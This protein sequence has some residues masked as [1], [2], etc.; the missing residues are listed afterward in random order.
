MMIIL[1]L[2]EVFKFNVLY[3]YLLRLTLMLLGLDQQ[4]GRDPASFRV[5][6]G[7]EKDLPRKICPARP[8]QQ[9]PLS[10]DLDDDPL[11]YS[12]EE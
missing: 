8:V 5:T 12:E 9:V 3:V 4:T 11:P 2:L 1:V 6:P 7:S 10:E